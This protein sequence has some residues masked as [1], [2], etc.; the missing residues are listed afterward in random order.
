MANNSGSRADPGQESPDG[1][2]GAHEERQRKYLAKKAAALFARLAARDAAA[3]RDDERASVISL[4]ELIERRP[5]G[6]EL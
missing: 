5:K 6:G 1:R 2:S 4:E 3:A